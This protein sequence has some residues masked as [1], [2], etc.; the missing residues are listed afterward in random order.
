MPKAAT[1]SLLVESATKCWPASASPSAA[2]TQA[3][4][5]CALAS[6]SWVVKVFEATMNSVVSGR[7]RF[8]TSPSAVPSTLE[9]KC[10]VGPPP[11][12]GVKASTAIAGPRSE[13]PMP[14]L[15]TSANFCPVAPR[16][17]PARTASAKPFICSSTRWTSGITSRPS[18]RTG[19]RGGARSAVCSTARFSEVLMRSPL[20]MA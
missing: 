17:V 4:A 15:T 16:R 1:A 6:V 7:Q 8:S 11:L 13:P 19:G 18:T 9:T 2:A 5:L 20:N 12:N 14:I 10:G 3:R